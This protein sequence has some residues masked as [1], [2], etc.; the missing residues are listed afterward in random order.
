MNLF[1]FNAPVHL[2]FPVRGKKAVSFDIFKKAAMIFQTSSLA[3]TSLEKPER[4]LVPHVP[5]TKESD[6]AHV[7]VD[8]NADDDAHVRVDGNVDNDAHVRVDGNVDDEAD[9]VPHDQPF[10]AA[11]M[12]SK[13]EVL[14]AEYF[15]KSR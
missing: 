5:R 1:V 9:L 14:L 6:N 8:G 10:V 11:P 2:E 4:D 12:S 7:R 3:E 13:P 15:N